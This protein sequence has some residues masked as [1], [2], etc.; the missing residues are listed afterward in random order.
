[1]TIY[2]SEEAADGAKWYFYDS[3]NGWVDYS[4]HA[5]FSPDRKSV[6]LEL[7]DGGYGDSDG[8]ANGIIVDPSGFGVA[9]WIKGVVSDSLTA[10]AI[11]ESTITISNLNLS[12]KTKLNGEF[13]SMVLPGTY[14]LSI[15]APNYQTRTLFNIEIS[16]ASIVT[17]NVA[18]AKLLT[19]TETS[20]LYVSIFGR[21]SE[22]E[23]NEY[24]R[25]SQTDKVVA[26]NTMLAT[27]AAGT[28]FGD[29]L[30][31]DFKFIEFIYK[32]TL[33]KTYAEDPD[34]I[35]YWVNELANGKSKGTVIAS[36]INAV[37]DK[38]YT[39]TSAQNQFMNKVT[40]CD[41]TADTISTVTDINDLSAF[42]GFISNVT[43]DSKTITAAKADV[44]AY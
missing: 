41:Y 1:V 42:V 40:V 4:E 38:A 24:W 9:S 39:G 22:G 18:L 44:D 14:D 10:K 16:E 19:K 8:V 35:D 31:D 7:K 5:T 20:Q 43:D 2:F 17:K 34:G 33:G 30:N 15:S 11:L 12:L 27:E 28:Y 26:A 37:M 21:A 36:L 32:N 6:R 23:G 25:G 29:T 3:I 13:L